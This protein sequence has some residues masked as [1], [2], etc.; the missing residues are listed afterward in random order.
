V[1]ADFSDGLAGAVER[2]GRSIVRVEARRRQSASGVVRSADGL[3][4]TAD[5]VLERDEDLAVGLPDG[6]SV[7]ARI[8][9]RDPGTDLALL[10]VDGA[11]LTPLESGAGPRVGNLV[12]LVARPSEGLEASVGFASTIGGPTRTSHGGRLD[13]YIR[14]DA[15]FYPGFS[16]GAAVDTTGRM[17]G[18]ATSHFGR[19]PGGLIIGLDTIG[20]VAAA[21][22]R[23]GRVKRGFLG[24]GSQVVA[25]PDALRTAATDSGQ[26]CALLVVSV[27]S[28]GPAERAG[29]MIGDL[30][31]AL[32][33]RPMRNHDDLRASLGSEQVGKTVTARVLRGGE[34]RELPITIGERE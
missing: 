31:V 11:G 10:K 19:G 1:L 23:H 29:L 24:L 7:G 27:E 2:A 3:V 9:G 32:G 16:G 15:I 22:E 5:H 33:G 28:G 12:L 30:L 20:R 14:T 34:P 17:I 6:R 13:G 21:L 25:L 4:L 18:L 26:E 8:V